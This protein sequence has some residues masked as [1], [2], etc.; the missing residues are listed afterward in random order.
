MSDRAF[1]FLRINERQAATLVSR[2]QVPGE[3]YEDARA[4]F[5]EKE[6]VDLTMA[7]I[8]INGWNRLAVS[9]RAVAGTYQP[10]S[11]KQPAL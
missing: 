1:P 10:V 8:A 9:F 7:V 3:V 11:G 5:S 2:D 6:L 4:Q